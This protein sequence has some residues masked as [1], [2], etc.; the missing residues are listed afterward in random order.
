MSPL[1]HFDNVVL[2]LL[3]KHP[4]HDEPHKPN[5]DFCP[6]KPAQV[7]ATPDNEGI[8]G[9]DFNPPTKPVVQPIGKNHLSAPLPALNQPFLCGLA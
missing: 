7:P 4:I 9:G 3:H 8:A 5:N 2:S 1:P 6:D